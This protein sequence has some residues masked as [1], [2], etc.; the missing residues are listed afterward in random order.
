MLVLFLGR[1]MHKRL[2]KIAK[3]NENK[4]IDVFHNIENQ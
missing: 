4:L 2:Q 1:N 3:K